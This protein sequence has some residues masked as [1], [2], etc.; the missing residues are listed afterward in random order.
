MEQTKVEQGIKVST[1]APRWAS[2]TLP[3]PPTKAVPK[4]LSV[5]SATPDEARRLIDTSLKDLWS[6]I[7]RFGI[8]SEDSQS[9]FY[10]Y[11]VEHI[12]NYD[13]KH[14]VSTFVVNL[15]KYFRWTKFNEVSRANR[16]FKAFKQKKK[17]EIR[18][19]DML[20]DPT[21]SV[22][23]MDL[24]DRS[25]NDL[26]KTEQEVVDLVGIRGF[27]LRET[28]RS[29]GVSVASIRKIYGKFLSKVAKSVS[30]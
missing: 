6:L 12:P 24:I 28:A 27:T 14:A 26:T 7:S 16:L 18:S 17:Y 21:T 13:C 3:G 23:N 11:L 1:S 30:D 22:F 15:V 4:A 10:I 9:E 19:G 2:V 29:T 8:V 5:V 25:M 20:S